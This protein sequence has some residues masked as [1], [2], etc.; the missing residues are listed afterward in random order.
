MSCWEQ[1]KY[2]YLKARQNDTAPLIEEQAIISTDLF[3]LSNPEFI[4]PLSDLQVL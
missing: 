2:R 3:A 1:Y 4:I